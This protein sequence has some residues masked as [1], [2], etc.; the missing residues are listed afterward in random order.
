MKKEKIFILDTSAFIAGFDPF[1]IKEKV[2]CPPLVKEELSPNSTFYLRFQTA[3]ENGKLEVKQPETRFT[4]A[5]IQS[6]KKTGDFRYLSEVDIQVLALALQLK[7]AN[8]NSIIVTD[9]YSIQ[10]VANKLGIEFASLA[11]FGIKY[12]FKWILYCPA[13]R[14]KYPPDSKLRKCE[15]CGTEL[16][17]K[18]TGKKRVKA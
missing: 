4:E 7:E 18:P 3:I 5:V 9:D 16:K 1:T 12:R 14:R 17:R 6:S 11:T 10:N 2:Y 15:I 8:K 13:C